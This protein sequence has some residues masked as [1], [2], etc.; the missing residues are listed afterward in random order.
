MFRYLLPVCGALFATSANAVPLSNLVAGATLSADDITLSAFTFVDDL[1]G[2]AGDANIINI[3]ADQADVTLTN[4]GTTSTVQI[5][6]D[7][8]LRLENFDEISIFGAFAIAS[9]ARDFTGVTISILSNT[10]TA[11]TSSFE[12]AI[13][14]PLLR[15]TTMSESVNNP[16]ADGPLTGNFQDIAWDIQGSAATDGVTRSIGV[17]QFAFEMDAELPPAPQ[18]PLPAGLPLLLS[19]LCAVGWM[20]SRKA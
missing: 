12:F 3:G 16:T 18:V 2:L 4:S 20:K 11:G 19:G 9:S 13:S 17:V 5:D 15:T 8:A 10:N 14:N 7:G 1:A 6:F